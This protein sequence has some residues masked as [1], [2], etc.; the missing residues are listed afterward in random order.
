QAVY[1]VLS[2]ENIP[3]GS[4]TLPVTLR[5]N[6]REIAKVPVTIDVPPVGHLK[7]AIVDEAGKPAAA[8]AGLYGANNRVVAPAEA[9]SFDD[10]GYVYRPGRTRPY[11]SMRYWPG[12]NSERQVFFV[13]GGFTMPLPAGDYK[14]IIG[15]GFEYETVVQSVHLAAGENAERTILVK[16]WIDMP[17]RGYYSGDGHVHYARSGEESNRR[18]LLWSRAE[19]VHM[20]NVM[21]MGDALKT[22]FEQ[23]AYGKAGRKVSGDYA[24]VPGQEDPRTSVEGH[25]LH[26]NLQSP[27]RR[28]DQYY[29][30]DLVFDETRRQGGLA[31]YEH[32]YQAPGRGFWVRQDMSMNVVQNRVDFV[33]LAQDGEINENLYY[34]FLNMGFKLAASGGSDVPY[35]NTIGSSRVYAYLGKPFDPDAWFAAIK[36][37]RTFVT[38]GPMLELTVNG[39]QPGADIQVQPGESVRIRATA[40]GYNVAPR[41][42]EVVA[43]GDV[44]QSAQQSSARQP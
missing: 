39:Q 28:P 22:Y 18:L 30:Y 29:L 34:E 24:L 23:Y 13:E 42:V 15:K 14:L 6:G 12:G 10:A 11:Q 3:P 44:I 1:I 41:Y 4:T 21:R 16:R 43:Q 36:G 37:G 19:D 25:T 17:A 33:E 8:V 2:I 27:F 35:G 7:V 38:T 32:M 5:S 40:S 31:G 20:A 9:G 26:M